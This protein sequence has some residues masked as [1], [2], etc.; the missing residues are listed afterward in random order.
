M[1]TFRSDAQQKLTRLRLTAS[2]LNKEI[3][4]K[5]DSSRAELH[6]CISQCTMNLDF[7]SPL[8]LPSNCSQRILSKVCHATVAITHDFEHIHISFFSTDSENGPDNETLTSTAQQMV[9][10]RYHDVWSFI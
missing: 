6:P 10:M 1:E 8:I 7:S 9:S 2:R 4:M 3:A 5:T